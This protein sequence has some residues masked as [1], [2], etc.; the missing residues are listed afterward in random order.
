MK[1]LVKVEGLEVVDRAL[2]QL[3]QALRR[4]VLLRALRRAGKPI[5][6]TARAS[7]PRGSDATRRGSKKDRRTGR[8]AT[9]GPGADS[10]RVRAVRA[11]NQYGAQVAVGP[12]RRH[13]YMRFS[14]F[15]TSRQAGTRWLTRAFEEHKARTITFIGEE[16]WEEIAR[17]AARLRTG[18]SAGTLGAKAREA[19]R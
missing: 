5:A 3:P 15:G 11:T 7:A 16:V 14:E 6:T 10:I 2:A 19:L 1:Q 13:F 4:G 12:D 8:A 17:T 9:I 18:A